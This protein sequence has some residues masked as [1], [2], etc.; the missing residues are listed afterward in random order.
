MRGRAPQR[1]SFFPHLWSAHSKIMRSKLVNGV[2]PYP[3][4]AKA[5]SFP[6]FNTTAEQRSRTSPT[7]TPAFAALLFDVTSSTNTPPALP[8]TRSANTRPSGRLS[9]TRR[10]PGAASVLVAAE[11]SA[12]VHRRGAPQHRRSSRAAFKLCTAS[13]RSGSWHRSIGEARWRVVGAS[14]AVSLPLEA[15]PLQSTRDVTERRVTGRAQRTSRRAKARRVVHV[16]PELQY[17]HSR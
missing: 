2:A 5:P 14:S 17:G 12:L 11:L 6:V 7:R 10:V 16:I 4:F 3:S 8:F 13:P 15:N 9:V 1:S